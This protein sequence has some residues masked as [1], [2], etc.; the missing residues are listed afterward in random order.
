MSKQSIAK[1]DGTE[2]KF[3]TQQYVCGLYVC[4]YDMKGNVVEQFNAGD[5]VTE[6]KFHRDMAR[7]NK[8]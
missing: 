8:K 7:G 2:Y 6:D 3:V 1:I 4:V 5:K